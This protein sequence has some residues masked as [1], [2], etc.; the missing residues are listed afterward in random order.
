MRALR[1]KAANGSFVVAKVKTEINVNR[2]IHLHR[3][4][5][6]ETVPA[7]IIAPSPF[8]NVKLRFTVRI[9]RCARLKFFA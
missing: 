7:A 9:A 8:A 3:S 6:D 2:I 5:P 4:N 1:A